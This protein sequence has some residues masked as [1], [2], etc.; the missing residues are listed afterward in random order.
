MPTHE[1]ISTLAKKLWIKSGRKEGRDEQN[2]KKAE[3][4]LI[5]RSVEKIARKVYRRQRAWEEKLATLRDL[6]DL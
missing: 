4:I 5:R 1:E 2:W 6:W 3:E